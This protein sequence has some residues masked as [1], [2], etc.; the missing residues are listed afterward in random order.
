MALIGVKKR[1]WIVEQRIP[2]SD[3]W[4]RVTAFSLEEGDSAIVVAEALVKHHGEPGEYRVL[5]DGNRVCHSFKR[6]YKGNIV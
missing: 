4:T 2:Q 1:E 6:D 5:N 3:Y